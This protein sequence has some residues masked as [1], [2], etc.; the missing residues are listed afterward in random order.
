MFRIVYGCLL[1]IQLLG[2]TF[3]GFTM[4]TAPEKKSIKT[5]NS[6]EVSFVPGGNIGLLGF[7][8]NLRVKQQSRQRFVLNG[9]F[10]ISR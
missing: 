9:K 1:A 6:K 7:A 8:G 3:P 10:G 4:G 5:K 2:Y